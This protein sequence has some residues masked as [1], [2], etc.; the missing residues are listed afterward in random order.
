MR[1]SEHVEKVVGVLHFDDVWSIRGHDEIID[2]I[3]DPLYK[4]F[5]A[6]GFW[7]RAWHL[8]V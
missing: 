6:W 3:S 7:L 5:G 4:G 1:W 2:D 8:G